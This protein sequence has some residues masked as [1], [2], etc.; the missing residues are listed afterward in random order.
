MP[1]AHGRELRERI[2]AFWIKIEWRIE[3]Q[4]AADQPARIVARRIVIVGAQVIGRSVSKIARAIDIEQSD[5]RPS[6]FIAVTDDD[7]G[8]FRDEHLV[9]PRVARVDI[10]SKCIDT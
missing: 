3:N 6:A 7:D 5:F 8:V 1:L 4:L 10:R 9:V 2:R